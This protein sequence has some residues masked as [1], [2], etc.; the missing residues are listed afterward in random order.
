MLNPTTQVM[1]RQII[2]SPDFI[3]AIEGSTPK[4]E[5]ATIEESALSGRE[6]QGFQNCIKLLRDLCIEP[7]KEADGGFIKT[8]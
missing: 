2:A 7:L 4:C 8:E 3:Q 5:G 6:R 1:L